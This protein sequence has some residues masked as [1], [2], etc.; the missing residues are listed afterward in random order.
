METKLS[1]QMIAGVEDLA[2]I[3]HYL[4][5]KSA[6]L[7]IDP[8]T[9]YDILLAVTE[10]VTNTLLYGY[11]DKSGFIEV[12]MDRQGDELV[13]HLRDHAEAFDP[14][15][16]PPPDISLPLEKRPIGGMGIY[17]T[18]Q[19]VDR[20]SYRRL[21]QGKNEI[22]LAIDLNKRG[23]EKEANDANKH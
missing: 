20:F 13:V 9:T 17:L 7:H 19:L 5:D 16:V 18:R 14:T 10:L 12:A 3:R 2:D 4:R 15:Q 11:P 22:T 1:L 21:P 8:T 23:N 6:L